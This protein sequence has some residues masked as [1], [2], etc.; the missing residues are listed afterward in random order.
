MAAIKKRM[1]PRNKHI[2][3]LQKP[4]IHVRCTEHECYIIDE[5]VAM[6]EYRNRAE[7]IRAAVN[8]FAGKEVFDDE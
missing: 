2:M 4:Q 5:L 1:T 8:A 7:Y 3:V 6:S